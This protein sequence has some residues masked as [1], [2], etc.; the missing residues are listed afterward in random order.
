MFTS[1][2]AEHSS[3]MPDRNT[4]CLA[5]LPFAS[6]MLCIFSLWCSMSSLNTHMP[7]VFS[8]I[9]LE[10]PALVCPVSLSCLPASYALGPINPACMPSVSCLIIDQ[11]FFPVLLL[12][13][14]SCLRS[15]LIAKPCLWNILPALPH[16]PHFF[17]ALLSFLSAN[18]RVLPVSCCLMCPACSLCPASAC[19]RTKETCEPSSLV[20]IYC[21]QHRT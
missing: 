12:S 13:V 17:P 9:G 10:C 7:L 1:K 5:A 21:R 19:P 14:L 16:V 11:C 4:T 3:Q 18:P 20:T 2:Q 8:T 6:C 15:V